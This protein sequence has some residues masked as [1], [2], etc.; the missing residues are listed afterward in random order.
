VRKNVLVVAQQI[1]FRAR[2][3]RVLQSAGYGAELAENPKRALELAG[4]K[5]IHAAIVVD[6][7]DLARL[8]QELCDKIPTTIVVGHRTD[9]IVRPG[10]GLQG[11]GVSL[12]DA[13]DEQKLLD[14][15]SRPAAS[16]GS[17]GDETVPAPVKIGDCKFDLAGHTFIDGGGGE[18]RLTRAETALL[19]A[20]VDS[21]RRVLSRDQLR[22]AVAGR[23][24]EPYDR[25]IDMLVARLRRKIEPDPKAP[26][27]I[28][29]VP[30]V[31]YKFD[32]RPQSAADGE[33]PPAL[34]PEPLNQSGRGEA[35]PAGTPGQ[36]SAA[37]HSE[38][39]RR[40]LTVLACQL[41]GSTALAVNL[42][43]EDFGGAIRRFQEMCTSVITHWGGAVI[44]FVGDEILASFGYPKG[45]EYDAERAVHAGLDLVERI[46]EVRS[47]CGDPLQV[48]IGIATGLVLVGE[49][50][51]AIGDAVVIAA[52]LR[53]ITPP[54]SVTVTA[55]TRKLLG[56][57][58]VYGDSKFEGVLGPEATYQVTGK[59]PIEMRFAASQTAKLTQFVGRQHELQQLSTLWELAKAGKGQVALLCGEPGI[60]KS[61]VTKT[62]SNLIAD[63]PHILM[64][65]QCSPHHTNSPFYPI[66]SHLERAAHFE[67]EDTPDLKLRKLEAMLSQ[68]GAATLADT[69]LYASLLSIPTD[70]FNSSPDLTS[71]R[72]R[73]LTIAALVRQLR[74]LALT[75]PVVVVLADAHWI[76]SS[77]LELLSRCIASIKAARVF[78]LINF[79]P[80]FFPPWLD[81]SHVTMLRLHR[82]AREQ[83]EAIILDVAGSKELP[84]ELQEQ[85]VSKSDGVPLFAEELTKTVLESGLLQDADDRYV[86]VG[87]LPALAVPT[88]L[89]GSLTARLDKLGEI[90]EIAQIGTA[91][92]REFSY[93][94][95]AAI[96]PVSSSTLQTALAHLAASELIFVRGE[97]PDSTYIFKHALVQDAAYATMVRSK[98]QQLHSR[99]ADA[100]TQGFP[101]TVETQ[102]ELVAHHLAQA[103]LTER[104]IEYFR[105]AARRA[106]ERSA[107]AEAIGH[108]TRALEMLESLPESPERERLALGLEVMLSQAMIAD[109]GYA[110]P[111][112]RNVLLRAKTRFDD[113][114][115]PSQKFP[116]LYGIW[117][118]H[119]VGGEGSE[120]TDAAMEFLAEA[121]RYKDTAALCIAHRMLG[122]TCVT[123]GEFATGL[124]HLEQARALYDSAHHSRYRHQYGQDIGAAALCYLSWALWHLGY[125]DRASEVAT[126][127]MKWAE[128]LSHPHTLVYTICHVRAFI[129][130]FSRRHEDTRSYAAMVVSLSTEN[131]FS[132]WLNCGW[133]FEGWAEICLGEVDRG[134][135]LLRAGIAAWHKRGARLWL[136][137]FL[138]LEAE[139]CAKAG[140]GDAALVVIEEALAIAKGTGERWA[141]AEVL[142]VKAGLLK[143]VAGAE[144]KEIEMILRSSLEIARAQQARCWELRAA[145]DL[146]RLWQG[147][148]RGRE[149][150]K[151]VQAIY[152]QFT[153][154]FDTTDLDTADLREAKALMQDLKRSLGRKPAR[155]QTCRNPKR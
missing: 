45:Y 118:G 78:V 61:R 32:V 65:Y 81:E 26:R 124:H 123:K 73:G 48:R 92:G 6:S 53:N 97:P 120:L 19:A 103:G 46:G 151:V 71:Q 25:S 136:P 62:W 116:I 2:I 106:I 72:Q 148:G 39:Q 70:K 137:I 74:D 142:R 119:Y 68:A 122:T 132:H 56:D 143:A 139:A 85:I 4:R 107:N 12:E 37:P 82:F 149:G 8:A 117:A 95:L 146:A 75:R 102:P 104:A 66:I 105:K 90:R 131:G 94:L 64:R 108:L 24:A 83:I 79:R 54:N 98:C 88:T 58:F 67:R 31:G 69:R 93:R 89:L 152:E 5:N 91:I 126:E 150:L 22:Y 113:L 40:Q 42:D 59:Q 145:C 133:I 127:A 18:V 129:D 130:L 33:A 34:E 17:T 38:P 13:L 20:F 16:P 10:H 47:Q 35:I 49:N 155:R 21:P 57:M 36:G 128:E 101:E 76:D 111:E 14:L 96:T 1:E 60:G 27:F 144:T 141:I 15:L 87:P 3:A 115:D 11:K 147:Q 153:E 7:P 110:A 44:N 112:T 114:T 77:T 28:L 80:E 23:G 51:P 154:G 121:E 86:A 29:S 30:G 99:I 84:R 109:R 50:Q 43:L 63:E 52:R 134:I 135:E 100:L 55:S 140:R 9:D 125:V 138:T 41:V